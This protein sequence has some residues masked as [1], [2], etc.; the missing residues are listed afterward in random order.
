MLVSLLTEMDALIA[1]RTLSSPTMNPLPLS[2][3]SVQTEKELMKMDQL[4]A[5]ISIAS[6]VNLLKETNARLAPLEPSSL[7]SSLLLLSASSAQTES[8]LR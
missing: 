5:L 4:R 2:A 3:S 6:L 7:T 8:F 1:P